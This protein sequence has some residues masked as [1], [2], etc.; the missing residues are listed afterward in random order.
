MGGVQT[1]FR[2][3][4][5]TDV[6]LEPGFQ[7]TAP[8]QSKRESHYKR[9][10]SAFPGWAS[11]PADDETSYDS[12]LLET[13]Q[14]VGL[15]PSD[16]QRLAERLAN[17]RFGI[18]G[19]GLSDIETLDGAF[20]LTQQ[21]TQDGL[22]KA[23]RA[24][25][26]VEDIRQGIANPVEAQRALYHLMRDFA[27]QGNIPDAV[28]YV[29]DQHLFISTQDT[30]ERLPNNRFPGTTTYRV[31]RQAHAA[32]LSGTLQPWDQVYSQEVGSTDIPLRDP[33]SYRLK[34]GDP[35]PPLL[36]GIQARILQGL[37]DNPTLVETLETA[38]P[39]ALASPQQFE[40][41]LQPVYQTIQ[42]ATGLQHSVP[43]AVRGSEEFALG[44]MILGGYNPETDQIDIN[45]GY[46]QAWGQTHTAQQVTERVMETLT[47]EL[48]HARQQELVK[49]SQQRPLPNTLPEADR[50]R[51]QDYQENVAVPNFVTQVFAL[52]G[53]IDN[54]AQAPFEH[55]AKRIAAQAAQ[56]VMTLP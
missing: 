45:H 50:L 21:D 43:M 55:D 10:A 6:A 56:L 34:P 33:H 9:T 11:T 51:L 39:K 53:D 38:V 2:S 37:Q 8:L 1:A 22:T 48:V 16:L 19:N 52:E 30:V 14:A 13:A 36:Q 35:L 54:Y 47:E 23:E 40:A 42:Q 18:S 27:K 41:A 20:D 7:D 17:N 25:Q 49:Q 29:D 3:C 5:Q 4:V 31:H 44:N 28:A 12:A 26:Q 46:F 32:D 15:P 24:L